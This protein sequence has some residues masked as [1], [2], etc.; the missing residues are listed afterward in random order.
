[1]RIEGDRGAVF[2][3]PFD[4]IPGVP[5]PHF[6]PG[7]GGLDRFGNRLFTSIER[8]VYPTVSGDI[9]PAALLVSPEGNKFLRSHLGILTALDDS[10]KQPDQKDLQ[11]D[12]KGAT[13]SKL[14]N[15]S[16]STAYLLALGDEEYVVRTPRFPMGQDK[17]PQPYINEMLQI[18][19]L[20][21][22]LNEQLVQ[23]GITLPTYL[24]ATGQ[25]SIVTY[26]KPRG[27]FEQ[28]PKI[29][30][31]AIDLV[32]RYVSD[33]RNSGDVLWQDVH[34]DINPKDF[35]PLI[36]GTVGWVDPVSSIKSDPTPRLFTL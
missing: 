33:Q 9:L 2:N 28:P 21:M 12:E 18:Q 14:R 25:V 24:L 7:L 30:R 31:R 20:S 11:I 16:M 35:V 26:L 23:L 15:G 1:M 5:Y 36:G 13:L 29:W 19:D 6:H 4:R 32:T 27:R 34:C 17:F 10:L 22:A 8:W 3:T